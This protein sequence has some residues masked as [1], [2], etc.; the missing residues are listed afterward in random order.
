[1]SE[2]LVKR[3]GDWQSQQREKITAKKTIKPEIPTQYG[4]AGDCSDAVPPAPGADIEIPALPN[5]EAFQN[6]GEQKVGVV[7]SPAVTYW[8]IMGG[9][10]VLLL[11]ITVLRSKRFELF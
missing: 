7:R 9:A 1:M 3:T 5:I 4:C 11:G 6:P 10:V 2:Q 8:L